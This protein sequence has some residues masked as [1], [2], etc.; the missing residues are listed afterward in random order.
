[1]GRNV[2]GILGLENAVLKLLTMF[3]QFINLLI[4]LNQFLGLSRYATHQYE[5]KMAE[6]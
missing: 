3:L 5:T 4:I 6:L 2:L 1:M